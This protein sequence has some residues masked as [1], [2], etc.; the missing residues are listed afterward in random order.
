MLGCNAVAGC[1]FAARCT[2]HRL[3]NGCVRPRPWVGVGV[4]FEV[5]VEV[6]VGV[7][8]EVGIEVG[9]EVAAA[10]AAAVPGDEDVDDGGEAHSC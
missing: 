7:G 1:C 9:L 6:E 5:D 4:G 2:R 10:A 8:A 3:R